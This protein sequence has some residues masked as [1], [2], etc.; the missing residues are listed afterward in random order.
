MKRLWTVLAAACLLT[1]CGTG[2]QADSQGGAQTDGTTVQTTTDTTE[3]TTNTATQAAAE[4][5][6]ADSNTQAAGVD[7]E[8][9]DWEH[10]RTAA[11]CAVLEQRAFTAEIDHYYEGECFS[12]ML[13][14]VSGSDIHI[15]HIPQENS[16]LPNY[17]AS[18]LY[19]IGGSWYRGKNGQWEAYME[20]RGSTSVTAQFFNAGKAPSEMTL[21]RVTGQG[22][23]VTEYFAKPAAHADE[24]WVTYQKDGT[25]PIESGYANTVQKIV[26]FTQEAAAI[27]LPDA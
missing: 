3:T 13:F 11:F 21:V 22:D 4:S 18:D 10:S 20:D 16:A 25:V 7:M 14:A 6:T 1:A 2:S 23:T 8:L 12:H 9:P 27:T 19:L 15:Q 26:R 5:T 17:P 24:L